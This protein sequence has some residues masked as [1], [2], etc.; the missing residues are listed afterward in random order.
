MT[1]SDI[2]HL[3]QAIMELKG[4]IE[5]MSERQEEM[6]EDVKK[7]KEAVYNPDEGLYARLRAIEQWKENQSK[8]QWAI[9]TTVIGLVVATVY[10]MVLSA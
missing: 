5:R 4:Q 1:N 6:V 10:K 8:L 7:I 2:T 3:T 9:T